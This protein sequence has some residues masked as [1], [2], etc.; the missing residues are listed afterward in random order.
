MAKIY[1]MTFGSGGDSRNLTGL[2]PT[3]LIFVRLT[4][5]ATIAPPAIT[6]S[7]TGWGLYQFTF[8]TTQPISFLVDAATTSPGTTGRY[9]TGQ[10]DPSDR[11]D[12]YGTTMI[13]IGTST[14]AQGV[15]MAAIGAT[16]LQA[17]IFQGTTLVAIGNTS[18]ALGQTA[19]A[20]ESNQG[21]TLVAIGNSLSA[22]GI[23]NVAIGTSIYA[24]EQA[25]GSTLLSIAGMG[26]S[27]LTAIGSTASLIGDLTHD[28]V[29]LF[30]YVKR[31]AE[32]DQGQETFV[33]GSGVLTMFDRT[34][35]TTL[36]QRTVTNS[37]SVVIKS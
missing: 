3:F 31:L 32:L 37:A 16:I 11:A 13:A 20:V 2:A 15:S 5:G 9:V 30:G 33:K 34:G 36:A 7:A 8:G 26:A 17:E 29:D 6:E 35:A 22:L 12:E 28:P 10:I 1:S 27:I 14:I 21:V 4:D 18:I 19:V 24:L 25:I 23:T